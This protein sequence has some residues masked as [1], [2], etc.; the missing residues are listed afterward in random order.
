MR[1]LCSLRVKLALS[2][3]S[4]SVVGTE[5]VLEKVL[6]LHDL[7]KYSNILKLISIVCF[8]LL[9]FFFSFGV[10]RY[11]GFRCVI[12]SV[13]G[14]FFFCF[15]SLFSFVDTRTLTLGVIVW[16]GALSIVRELLEE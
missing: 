13:F 16:V 15:V 3:L 1:V 6:G 5:D 12:C 7:S 14:S 10:F 11:K 4:D 2:S 8:F 9:L